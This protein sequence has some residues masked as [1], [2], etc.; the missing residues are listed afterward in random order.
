MQ[1]LF[2]KIINAVRHPLTTQ[3]N[4]TLPHCSVAGNFAS[5]NQ[6]LKGIF[7]IQKSEITFKQVF[8]FSST[9]RSCRGTD[10]QQH[11]LFK[12]RHPLVLVWYKLIYYH[13]YLLSP[14]LKQIQPYRDSFRK[15]CHRIGC[16]VFPNEFKAAFLFL[17][18]FHST[19]CRL[20][21]SKHIYQLHI[22]FP[23]PCRI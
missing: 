14:T 15:V 1:T 6:Y 21:N 12:H 3:T 22:N 8:K 16:Q 17:Q 18:F 13:T 20:L 19:Q 7:K 11:S 2:L 4:T 23:F 10:L 5:R 9:G